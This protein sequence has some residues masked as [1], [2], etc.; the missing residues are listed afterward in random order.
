[1]IAHLCL[2][3]FSHSRKPLVDNVRLDRLVRDELARCRYTRPS[4]VPMHEGFWK[5]V[6]RRYGAFT[7]NALSKNWR[8]R[9]EKRP[10]EI[11]RAFADQ[12]AEQAEY[13]HGNGLLHDDDTPMKEEEE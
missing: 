7:S 12:A 5:K 13:Q 1:L 2:L 10:A 4:D 11:A 3:L 8:R 9:H 6:Y